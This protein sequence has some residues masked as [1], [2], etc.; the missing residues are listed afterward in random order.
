MIE[1]NLNY[2]G[3]S[4][5]KTL[6]E[7]SAS[8]LLTVV[9]DPR[10]LPI[11][12]EE[13]DDS[14]DKDGVLRGERSKWKTASAEEILAQLFINNTLRLMVRTYY[15]A[16]NTIGFGYKTDDYIN[17]NEKYLKPYTDDDPDD[18][19]NVASNLLH[20]EFHNRGM[21]HDF[22]ETLVR[23][24]SVCYAANR[25]FKRAYDVII[26]NKDIEAPKTY[27]VICYRS[28]K[29]FGLKRCYKVAA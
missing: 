10:F 2:S 24:Y 23:K 29:T 9:T 12:K 27:Q 17:V 28:W 3:K 16:L 15:T 1:L 21:E 19:K 14:R 11:F 5:Y 6:F 22:K 20:E 18:R 26:L 7:V 25:A 13:L 8:D 4:K